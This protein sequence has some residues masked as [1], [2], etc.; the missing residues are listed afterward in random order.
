MD[1]PG[2]MDSRY[3]PRGLRPARGYRWCLLRTV[4]DLRHARARGRSISPP[5]ARRL[6]SRRWH[7]T[8]RQ[9]QPVPTPRQR[10]AYQ[11]QGIAQLQHTLTA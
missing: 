3:V 5:N 1:A 4:R 6:F 8:A 7:R 10:T 2:S 11:R 9:C